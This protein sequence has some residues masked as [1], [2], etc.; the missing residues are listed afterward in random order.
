MQAEFLRAQ[1]SIFSKCCVVTIYDAE[2]GAFCGDGPT[3]TGMA[4]LHDARNFCR[5]NNLPFD[6]VKEDF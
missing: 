1:I 6:E 5:T 2:T 3:T 4:K